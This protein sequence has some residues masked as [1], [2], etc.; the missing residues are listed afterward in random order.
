MQTSIASYLRHL[1]TLLPG[2]GAYLL[3]TGLLDAGEAKQ[4]DGTIEE[5]LSVIAGMIAVAISRLVMNWLAEHF[6]S[7]SILGSSSTPSMGSSEAKRFGGTGLL[8]MWGACTLGVCMSLTSCSVLSSAWT[9][10]PIPGHA[11]ARI[12]D[13]TS[14]PIIIV[15]S[16]LARA[17]D[18]AERSRERGLPQKTYGLYNAGTAANLARLAIDA[19]K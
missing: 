10:E 11:V 15:A 4:L 5:A 9:G 12:D 3:S 14:E 2:L 6:P 17:E 7:L 16:D 8:L 1:I 19:T 13:P 18:E